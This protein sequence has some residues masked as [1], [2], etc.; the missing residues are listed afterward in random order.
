MPTGKFTHPASVVLAFLL[1]ANALAGDTLEGTP[2]AR[3]DSLARD[4]GEVPK[5]TVVEQVFRL[6]N[7]GTAELRI[8]NVQLSMPGMNIRVKQT[9][10]AGETTEVRI[11]WDTADY[12]REVEGRAELILNDPDRPRVTLTLT[13]I[14]FPPIDIL[15]MP[16]IFMSQF[17]GER[18][19]R[20]LTIRSNQQRPFHIVRLEPRGSHFQ[21][22]YKAVEAGKSYELTVTVPPESPVGRYRESV[23]VHTDDPE[24]PR[25]SIDVNFLV[26]PEVFVS[27]ETIDFGVIYL[28]DIR[29]NPEITD[30]L[31]QTFV[32]NRKHGEMSITAIESDIRILDMTAE[33]ATP[34]NAFKID[35]G[36]KPSEMKTGAFEGSVVIK[37]SDPDHAKLVVPVKGVVLDRKR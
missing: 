32:I 27:V 2:S 24:R 15:P 12:V 36:L 10:P 20:S 17:V 18:A 26:K 13:G 9:I 21:A 7:G 33:P 35:V 19:V 22:N 11:T 37:T 30:L 23:I 1:A 34:S 3:F 29:R 6:T 28:S 5:G 8:E 16:V 31:R 4:F 14:V 25:I